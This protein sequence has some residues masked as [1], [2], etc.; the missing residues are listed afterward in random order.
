MNS[1]GSTGKEFDSSIKRGKPLEF[2]VGVGY[3]IKGWDMALLQMKKGE[4]RRIVIPPV[5]GY[6]SR[7][8]PGV[9][10]ADATLIFEV[11]LLDIKTPKSCS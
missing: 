3:V 6:G 10:P 2:V 9:I 5:L 4:K 8:V 7:G 11:E 1:N